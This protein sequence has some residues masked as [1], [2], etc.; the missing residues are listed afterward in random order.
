M[1][2]LHC[3]SLCCFVHYMSLHY[4]TA[5]VLPAMAQIHERAE[6]GPIQAHENAMYLAKSVAQMRMSHHVS[7]QGISRNLC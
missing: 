7:G 6:L 2:F 4:F 1:Q 5:L 3:I